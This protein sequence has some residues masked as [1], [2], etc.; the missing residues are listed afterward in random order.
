M[1]IW[2]P[3]T[4]TYKQF[5]PAFK[6]VWRKRKTG[7]RLPKTQGWSIKWIKRNGELVHDY[8]E[9]IQDGNHEIFIIKYAQATFLR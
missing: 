5:K 2:V 4:T 6:K 8:D 3:K 7:N 1:D 9:T